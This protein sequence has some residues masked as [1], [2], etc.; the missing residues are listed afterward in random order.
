MARVMCGQQSM[1]ERDSE[2]IA[3]GF[4]QELGYLHRDAVAP[5]QRR[6]A[7]TAVARV[8]YGKQSMLERDS[9]R[10]AIGFHQELGYLQT[11][12]DRIGQMQGK[13]F[14][15]EVGF[16]CFSLLYLQQIL[17]SLEGRTHV[18]GPMQR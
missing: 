8:M 18:N 10:I 4:H 5:F 2:R 9:E 1:L 15:E 3:I 7:V 17:H 14:V 12:F 11:C 13:R 6:T 16:D